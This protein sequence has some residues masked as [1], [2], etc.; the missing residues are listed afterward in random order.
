MLEL[1]NYVIVHN[2]YDVK[3]TEDVQSI[4]IVSAYSKDEALQLF[5]EMSDDKGNSYVPVKIACIPKKQ[6]SAGALKPVS[7]RTITT[8]RYYV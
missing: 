7:V 6:G 2:S 4:T 3:Y 8:E 1:M 5:K